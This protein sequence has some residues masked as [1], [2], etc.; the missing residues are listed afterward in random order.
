MTYRPG[1]GLA[2]ERASKWGSFTRASRDLLNIV[3]GFKTY[4][5]GTRCRQ[6]RPT[7]RPSGGEKVAAAMREHFR[8]VLDQ[9]REA[10]TMQDHVPEEDADAA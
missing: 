3:L 1:V 10:N 5:T 2:L 7:G 9:L 6:S 8:D 4:W